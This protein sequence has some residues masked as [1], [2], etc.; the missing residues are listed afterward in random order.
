MLSLPDKGHIHLIAV[1]GTAM[2]SLAAMLRQ[3]GYR[4]TGSDLHV[5]PPMSDFLRGEGIEIQSGFAAE[6]LDPAPDLV[7][8]GNA[9][10]RGNPEAEAALERRIPYLCLPE[11]VRDLFLRQ[12]RPAVITGTHGKTTTTALAAHL[13]QSAGRDPGFLVAGIPRDFPRPYQLG[14][15]EYFVIEGDEYDSAFFAKYA[16]FLYYLP[17]VLVIN[18][19]EFDH[20]DIYRDLSEIERAFAQ[21]IN[22]VPGNGLVLANGDDPV[23][24]RLLPRSPAPVQ[25]FGLG[26]ACDLRAGEIRPCEAGQRFTAWRGGER[27]GEFRVEMTGQHNVRNALAAVGVGLRAGLDTEELGRGLASFKGM[28]RRQEPLGEVAGIT[29]IDDFAHHPTAVAAT[30]QGLRQAHPDRRLWA[31]FEP[32]SASNARRTFEDR[33]V[34]AFGPADCVVIGAVPRPERA[35]QDPPFSPARLAGTLEQSGRRAWHLAAA[36]DIAGHLLDSLRPGDVVVF[37][38][39]GAFGGVQQKVVEGLGRAP[40][41][42]TPAA[43]TQH[44][45]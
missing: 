9:V 39:N 29:L 8:I 26:S 21:V 38:S 4:V 43:G 17:E 13:L 12:R 27:L 15:G 16:K 36:D 11:V 6:H 44:R 3:L 32:A 41:P 33:Y 14:S 40:S 28:K 23:V 22:I 35:G 18:N 25:T 34:E 7:V 30:L 19:I 45:A 42:A 37:M 31:V 5:Y 2:G 1:C 24:S 20:A 10:S